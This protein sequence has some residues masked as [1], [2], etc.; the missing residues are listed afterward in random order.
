MAINFD[1]E[2]KLFYLHTKSATYILGFINRYLVHCYW[3]K[4]LKNLPDTNLSVPHCSRS[5]S[6]YDPQFPDC[7]PDNLPMEY[8]TFGSS[9]LR[10]PA[11]HAIY[12]DGSSVS[13]LRYL[14]HSIKK[15]RCEL[16]GLPCVSA[17]DST[18]SL[19]L[20][21]HDEKTGA[22]VCLQYCVFEDKDA[23]TRSV[24]VKNNSKEAFC[25][26][27]I[28]SAS[29]DIYGMDFEL[30]SLHGASIR[31]RHVQ[32]VPL[33]FGN[34]SID[35]KRGASGHRLNPFIALASKG[36]DETRGDVYAMNF[37]YSGN[38]CAG[39]EVD[40]Y[41]MTRM[42][43][44][45]NPFDFSWKLLSGES[46]TS[47]EVVM[48]Y[49]DEGFGKMSRIYHDLYRENL[50]RS[51]YALKERPVLINNWET[52]YFDFS[53]EKIVNIAKKAS[54]IGVEL[55][56]LDDGWF[57]KRN[58]D[59]SS[60]GDW[61]VNKD[62]LP[63]GLSS[64]AEKIKE[65]G[66]KFGLWFEP[67]MISPDSNL[68]REHPEWCIQVPGRVKSE[69]RNQYILDFSNKAVCDYI[70][71][72][73][74]D[75]LSGAD[76]S[77][78]KW[79]MNRNMSET[80]SLTLPHD[81]QRETA[82]RYILGLYYVVDTLTKRFPDVLF[83]SCAAG[84]GRFD[85]GMLCY[86][87]QVWT[88]DNTDAGER[89]KIQY[90]T[91]FAYPASAMGAH[92]SAV[93]NHQ[94]HRTTS[95]KSRCE[96]AMNGQFGFEL[97]LGKISDE[98]LLMAKESIKKYKSIRNTVHFGDMY[99]IMSPFESNNSAIEYISKDKSQVV[100]FRGNFLA[101]GYG[102]YKFMKLCNLESEA[103][104]ED[105]DKGI[106]MTGEALMNIGIAF[107]DPKDFE[108]EIYIFEKK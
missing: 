19:E 31:E 30:V 2:R 47:P 108:S 103:L 27:K 59:N 34:Q 93:P 18:Q 60:L 13:D 33:F 38:Y 41:H 100:V 15:G 54:Q 102:A 17:D 78:L 49:S 104:Y 22:D 106:S 62:K 80:G 29:V 76:I 14:S 83:E 73:L 79:D 6:P 85:A 89:L 48:V 9:D 23:I 95:F 16:C 75:I 10:S 44:G 26:D 74:S 66:M 20:V 43:M 32:K 68:Y 101:E 57:G 37:V 72:S 107:R 4:T 35:S 11:F 105:K 97:D 12:S 24:T 70:I 42:Y 46:F 5:Q 21:L 50:C 65:T 99:R 36:A 45:L 67:E 90:G 77:Y 92:V 88:S 40:P 69:G 98:E 58:S 56:V 3:G 25:I 94:V 7:Q 91:S 8:P 63:S 1:K 87:P 61:Y 55:M 53:E 96:V 52:T 28:L 51:K 86:M 39:A 84:G 82:H 81:R 71:N 64:L